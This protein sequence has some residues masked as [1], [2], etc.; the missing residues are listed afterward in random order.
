M[1]E[2]KQDL[3]IVSA[4]NNATNNTTDDN[5]K[6]R[7]RSGYLPTTVAK[8]ITSRTLTIGIRRSIEI[9]LYHF[10]CLLI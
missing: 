6:G 3:H 7:D 1:T 2:H 8:A 4:C 9:L 10:T 5:G